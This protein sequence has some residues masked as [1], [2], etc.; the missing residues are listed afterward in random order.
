MSA[1][2]SELFLQS[3]SFLNIFRMS[4][5]FSRCCDNFHKLLT[6]LAW[7]KKKKILFFHVVDS[8]YSLHIL[9]V[10][11]QYLYLSMRV[12]KYAFIIVHIAIVYILSEERPSDDNRKTVESFFYKYFVPLN[13]SWQNFCFLEQYYFQLNCISAASILAYN[14]TQLS[15]HF[16]FW[17]IYWPHQITTTTLIMPL[18]TYLAKCVCFW[19]YQ[20]LCGSQS[21]QLFRANVTKWVGNGL[22]VFVDQLAAQIAYPLFQS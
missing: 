16:P 7:F 18:Q 8:E 15:K 13:G 10:Q 11:H 5:K 6:Q 22:F 17:H 12:Q 21:V 1:H 9:Y 2:V 19:Y 4:A 14:S 3:S 20:E